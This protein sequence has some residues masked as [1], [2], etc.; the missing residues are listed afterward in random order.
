MAG[1]ERTEANSERSST[2]GQVLSKNTAPCRETVHEKKSQRRQQTSLLY[3]FKELQKPPQP[4]AA[5][6]LI[7][8]QPSAS[9]QESPPSK[10][11]WLAKDLG[12]VGIFFFTNKSFLLILQG[13]QMNCLFQQP[14][15]ALYCLER[16]FYLGMYVNFCFPTFMPCASVP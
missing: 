14:L 10:R 3:Y 13:F 16:P 6:T 9:R 2:V 8:Q 1:C 12:T 5:T 4:P 11:L 7:S 15:S